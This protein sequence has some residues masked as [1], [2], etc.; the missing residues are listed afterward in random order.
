M[1]VCVCVFF[2]FFFFQG[3]APPWFDSPLGDFL[4]FLTP[5]AAH[6]VIDSRKGI[7]FRIFCFLSGIFLFLAS[8]LLSFLALVPSSC[9]L[10]VPWSSGPV[11]ASTIHTLAGAK[12]E[13]RKEGKKEG[14]QEGKKAG[15]HEGRK[16]PPML[17]VKMNMSGVITMFAG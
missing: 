4:H 10:L 1:C 13:G 17:T 12:P 6:I 7:Y 5:Q 8:W 9:G 16:G 14:R 3:L 15:R 11:W 2:S